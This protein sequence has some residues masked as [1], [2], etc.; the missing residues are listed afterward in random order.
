M[1]FVKEILREGKYLVATGGGGRA[2]KA[3]TKPDLDR[4]ANTA[5]AMLR[6]GLRITAPWEHDP[7][8]QPVI[9]SD[10]LKA[11]DY[12]NA[13]YWQRFYTAKNQDGEFSF[14]GVLEAPGNEEQPDT[15]AYRVS[16][17][18][19]D[20]SICM[21]D[22]FVDGKGN[23]WQ[24]A[25]VHVALPQHPVEPGQSNFV[26][27]P[28]EEVHMSYIS[29]GM[30]APDM[31]SGVD[32][33]KIVEVLKG[34]GLTLPEGTDESNFYD[35]LY[36]VAVQK[37]SGGGS[38]AL[39]EKPDDSKVETKP[40]MMSLTSEQVESLLKANAVNPA[41]GKAFVKE[42]FQDKP[43]DREVAQAKALEMMGNALKDVLK[44]RYNDRI[45]AL[46]STG[47]ITQEYADQQL[48]PLVETVQMSLTSEG[49]VADGPVDI[50]LRALESLPK[51]APSN[52]GSYQMGTRPAGGTVPTLPLG[53]DGKLG[54]KEAADLVNEI[55][56]L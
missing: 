6:S 16:R 43:S 22:E 42:D 2:S 28:A 35:R 8:A 40:L 10:G 32:I 25:L 49:K 38:S 46:V 26:P 50:T 45:N 41:T 9:G 55:L 4:M 21:A 39:E 47:A 3:F 20:T 51:Q 18:A 30:K 15:P 13:G 1:K 14:Y 56:K 48:A 7:K 12:G 34:C 36:A 5:N 23:K 53:A 11:V 52:Q 24:G 31:L 29:M 37:S 17:T 19:R 54:D 33:G 27:L 44:V